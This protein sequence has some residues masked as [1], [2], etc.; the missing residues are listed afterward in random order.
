MDAIDEIDC[1]VRLN[2][3]ARSVRMPECIGAIRYL[4]VRRVD[5]GPA[6][7]HVSSGARELFECAVS[8]V[9]HGA[10]GGGTPIE[11]AENCVDF[12]RRATAARRSALLTGRL[13]LPADSSR[14]PIGRTG[15]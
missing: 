1:K 4:L 2:P 12:D 13:G 6:R 10:V 14:Y 9:R 7:P 15:D 8:H 11:S 3:A 5:D